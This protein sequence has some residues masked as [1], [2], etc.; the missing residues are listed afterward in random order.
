MLERI[1]VRDFALLEALDVE[2][3]DDLAIFTGETGA[4]KSLVVGSIGFLFGARADTDVIREGAAECSVSGILDVSRNEAALGWLKSRGIS[5]EDGKVALRRGIRTNGRSYAWICGQSVTRSDLAEFTALDCD[6][7]GQHE[8][9]SLL[10][11]ESH[12]NL[13]DRFGALESECAA[14]A[15]LYT[16][17]A[18]EVR[19]YR[20]AAAEA[21]K[22][23]RE[24][25]FLAFSV[26]EL[27]RAALKKGEDEE[28]AA[29]E[30]VLGQHEK[31]HTAAENAVQTLWGSQEGGV[32]S[33][34]R[35]TKAGLE[36]TAL[37]DPR[38][39]TLSKRFSDAYFEI[40]DIAESLRSYFDGL[41]F[42]PQRLEEI[43][44]RQA[45][46]RKLK[47]KYGPTIDAMIARLE[48][49]EARLVSGKNWDVDKIAMEAAIVRSGSAA[50]EAA[51]RLS[52]LRKAA[53]EA[54]S[55]KIET[56]LS[57]LGMPHAKFW[58]E[59]ASRTDA[60]GSLAPG[61]DGIDVVEFKIA[62]NPGESAKPL[63]KIASGG[64]LSR[65][66]LAIKT[67]L[68]SMDTVGT[69]IFDE[70]DSGIGGEVALA[71]G[72]RLKELSRSHQVFCVTHLASIAAM[73]GTQYRVGK[74]V[75][76]D[77][78]VTS[79]EPLAGKRREEEIARMLAGD[80][81]G[82]VSIA[83]AAALLNRNGVR[84]EN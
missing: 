24:M 45:E 36:N 8:H 11:P 21:A 46:L 62:P 13:L 50:Q 30:R 63:A 55:E 64:E 16:K 83:H 39:E 26:D 78:T 73:A 1:E 58:I 2:F 6:I 38:A 60:S 34:L 77:R 5:A 56:G 68:A 4:G 12:M 47:K 72:Q 59:V 49:D 20:R 25:D 33:A 52:A 74:E 37:I 19:T 41:R 43:E 67:V 48:E 28:L 42:D 70:I 9:Q 53:A 29:E 44:S 76:G 65:V 17:W 23:A 61:P 80:P 14:Y 3:P 40:E 54:L 75:R 27:K 31:L 57:G 84:R 71:V 82:A 81:E 18:D 35:K 51:L 69:L 32:L 15:V 10:K 22:M 66:A 7:H 79:V